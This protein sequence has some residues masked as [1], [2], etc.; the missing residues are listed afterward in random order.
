MMTR[1]L[2][3]S[4]KSLSFKETTDILIG[5]EKALRH[6]VETYIILHELATYPLITEQCKHHKTTGD[7]VFPSGFNRF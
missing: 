6:S 1:N 5:L 7:A 2:F 3:V 4:M